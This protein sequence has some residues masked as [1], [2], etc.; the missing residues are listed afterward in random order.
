MR[1][2]AAVMLTWTIENNSTRRAE[3]RIS[4]SQARTLPVS[5]QRDEKM[6][7]RCSLTDGWTAPHPPDSGPSHS[8]PLITVCL[9]L[10]LPN[11]SPFKQ[12]LGCQGADKVLSRHTNCGKVAVIKCLHCLKRQKVGMGKDGKRRER[13]FWKWKWK[14]GLSCLITV[15]GHGRDEDVYVCLFVPCF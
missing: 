4:S 8:Q 15:V 3:D 12:L 6:T 5:K 7:C 14:D 2:W 10:P 1:V 11:I 13:P 9:L